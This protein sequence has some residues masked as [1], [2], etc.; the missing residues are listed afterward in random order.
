MD[1][2]FSSALCVALYIITIVIQPKIFLMKLAELLLHCLHN[3][4]LFCGKCKLAK[5]KTTTWP[6]HTERIKPF[7]DSQICSLLKFN[8]ILVL[9]QTLLN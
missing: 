1:L 5:I 2:N 3:C 4:S 8:Y 6:L 7:V 9:S